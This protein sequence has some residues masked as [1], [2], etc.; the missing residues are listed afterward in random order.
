MKVTLAESCEGLP[1]PFYPPIRTICFPDT[2]SAG[3]CV[4]VT[5]QGAPG[6]EAQKQ[7]T[8]LASR[9]LARWL[10]HH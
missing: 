10:L 2:Q 8:V 9:A 5:E 7:R 3:S 6:L 1:G 4:A